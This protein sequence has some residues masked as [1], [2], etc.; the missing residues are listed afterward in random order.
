MVSRDEIEGL[1]ERKE[2]GVE[3]IDEEASEDG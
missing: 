3:G 2:V 1:R